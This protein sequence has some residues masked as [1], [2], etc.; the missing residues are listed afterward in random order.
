MIDIAAPE[1]REPLAQQ[2]HQLLRSCGSDTISGV[3]ASVG[4]DVRNPDF[5]RAS[6]EVIKGEIDRFCA[7]CDKE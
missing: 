2:A 1:H 7:L 3:A 5:W 6:L 4:I